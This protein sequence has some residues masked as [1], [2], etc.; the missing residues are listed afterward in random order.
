MVIRIMPYKV[1]EFGISDIGLVR[2]NN[3]DYWKSVAGLD[4]YVLADGM[5]GHRAGEVASKVAVDALCRLVKESFEH[6]KQF[7]LEDTHSILEVALEQT[8]EIVYTMGRKDQELRGMGTTLCCL[9]F[10]PKGLVFAHVGDSRI[11]RFR[12]KKL[13]LLTKDHSLLRELMDLG[14]LTESQAPEF[15]YKNII[16]KAIGT[17]PEV[18]PSVRVTEVTHDDI[19]LMCT[20]GVSDMLTTEEMEEIINYD[21]N[22]ENKAKNMI[23]QALKK[24]GS[25]NLTI[26]ITKVI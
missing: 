13:E 9:F 5:G 25:D 23:T 10:H 7:S 15:L 4:F 8:N 3:E 24:G 20:D 12:N 16:T 6:P 14:Q 1:L 11:Y 22:I 26:V 17:E 19:Y 21:T 2:Q 18:E